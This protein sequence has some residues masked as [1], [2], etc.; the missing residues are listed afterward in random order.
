MGT[1]ATTCDWCGHAHPVAALCARRPTWGRR[2][3]L[4]LVGA[5][6]VGAALP[7]PSVVHAISDYRLRHGSGFAVPITIS[8]VIVTIGS[9]VVAGT[10]IDNEVDGTRYRLFPRVDAP[11]G[12]QGVIDLRSFRIEPVDA[13]RF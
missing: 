7:A 11:Q 9:I 2:G 6:L 3:F 1:I 8:G 10:V 5:G 12:T 4:A 13:S